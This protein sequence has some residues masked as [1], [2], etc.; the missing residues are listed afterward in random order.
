MDCCWHYGPIVL[1]RNVIE[2][3]TNDWAITPSMIKGNLSLKSK[4]I[5]LLNQNGPGLYFEGSDIWASV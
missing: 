5:R 3:G 2:V 1:K 4:V